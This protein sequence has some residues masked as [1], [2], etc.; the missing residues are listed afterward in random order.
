[1]KAADNIIAQNLI[2]QGIKPEQLSN[3]IQ[4]FKNKYS[5]L[6]TRVKPVYNAKGVFS[7]YEY[8]DTGKKVEPVVLQQLDVFNQYTQS[9]AP[10]MM[11]YN[12]LR[13]FKNQLNDEVKNNTGAEFYNN[14]M[15][16][17]A[18][19]PPVT[20][21]R[22]GQSTRLTAN[23]LFD[24]L[25]TGSVKIYYPPSGQNTYGGPMASSYQMPT[26]T[27]AVINGVSYDLEDTKL[28][29]LLGVLNS[30]NRIYNS[31]DGR[32]FRK[33]QEDIYK[34]N[35]INNVSMGLL[36]VES[37]FYKEKLGEVK[38]ILGSE[39]EIAGLDYTTGR[40]G[41]RLKDQNEE[42]KQKVVEFTKGRPGIEYD[43]TNDVF[44][45]TGLVNTDVTQNYSPLERAIFETS[46]TPYL[47]KY[48]GENM[49]SMDSGSPVRLSGL[50]YNFFWKRVTQ[51]N[52]GVDGTT[53][54]THSYS[55]YSELDLTTPLDLPPISSPFE[56]VANFRM[57]GSNPAMATQLIESKARP[58]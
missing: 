15:Q 54:L 35:L 31:E 46:S 47:G 1:M 6:A 58:E 19:V 26:G 55:I 18:K 48:S 24:G 14:M 36:D 50:P 4:E 5:D 21:T 49:W 32:K 29:P 57:L 3:S 53:L 41:V 10:A 17:L 9:L 40:L 28:G 7:H 44:F 39:V 42:T 34:S 51:K 56:L 2:K 23:Q 11:K 22:G 16:Q 12:T 13:S 20:I 33:A 38:Q 8:R 25:V 27:R 45:V 37:S 52:Q 43:E 30:I